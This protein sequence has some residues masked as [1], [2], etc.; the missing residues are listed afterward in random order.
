MIA[1]NLELTLY[2][3]GIKLNKG[4]ARL[5]ISNNKVELQEVVFHGGDGTLREPARSR[6]IKPTRH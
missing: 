2:D 3:Q 1:E 4:V 5:A 6:S